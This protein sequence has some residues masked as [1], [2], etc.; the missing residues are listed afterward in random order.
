MGSL[1]FLMG[2]FFI[3]V[4]FLRPEYAGINQLRGN[5]ASKEEAYENQQKI[6]VEVNDLLNRYQSVSGLRDAVS[7][8]IPN[9]ED[10]ATLINQL[11]SLARISGL[12]LESVQL[13]TVPVKNTGFSSAGGAALP[14]LKSLQANLRLQGSYEGLK[15]FLGRIETNIR[16]MDPTNIVI[17][18]NPAGTIYTYEV[19]VNTYYQSL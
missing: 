12:V 19:A 15:L 2:S 17:T 5:L 10:Y 14:A 8:A 4:S 1:A 16:V 3:F 13:H 9:E 6:I 18:P 11:G 7:R